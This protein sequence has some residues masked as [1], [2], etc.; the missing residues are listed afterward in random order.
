MKKF[1][2]EKEKIDLKFYT[3]GGINKELNVAGIGVVLIDP[4]TNESEEFYDHISTPTT[5][6]MAE[7]LAVIAA[8]ELAE[9]RN[10]KNIE[11][12]SDSAYIVNC[13][14]DE[15]YKKWVKNGWKNNEGKEISN[16]DLWL[17]LLPYFPKFRAYC[18]EN[19][20]YFPP[21]QLDL[22]CSKKLNVTMVKV[23]GH[24]GDYYN[25]RADA[26]ATMGKNDV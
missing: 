22:L 4:I 2:K 26:L 9:E 5:N 8:M 14:L 13:Y 23:K 24:S 19:F 16:K 3:D 15:W 25:D 7:M 1:S 10:C 21:G 12:Y 11:I 17:K 18:R 20:N 6:Q